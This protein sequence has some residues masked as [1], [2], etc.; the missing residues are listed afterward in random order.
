MSCEHQ[1]SPFEVYAYIC[2]YA[3]MCAC[4]CEI[5][6]YVC[7]FVQR[8]EILWKNPN[9]LEELYSHIF[10]CLY[11]YIYIYIYMHIYIY[12]RTIA[13]AVESIRPQY[14]SRFKMCVYSV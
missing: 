3:C 8:H 10:S 11:I 9:H 4:T 12:S 1:G 2:V 13:V 5:R 6:A 14:L 7:T